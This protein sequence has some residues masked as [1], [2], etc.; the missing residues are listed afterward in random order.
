MFSMTVV[1]ETNQDMTWLHKGNQMFYLLSLCCCLVNRDEDIFVQ[2]IVQVAW[3]K[4][5]ATLFRKKCNLK[6]TIQDSTF[7]FFCLVCFLCSL[8]MILYRKLYTH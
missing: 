6:M 1:L 7:G 2:F 5:E 3:T 8:I 4:L